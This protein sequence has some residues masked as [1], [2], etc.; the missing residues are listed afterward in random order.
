[1]IENLGKIIS[2]KE[3]VRITPRVLPTVDVNYATSIYSGYEIITNLHSY[4]IL[5]DDQCRCCE[6]WGYFSSNDDLEDFIGGDLTEVYLTDIN[7]NTKALPCEEVEDN[8]RST[9]TQF[10]NFRLSNGR[11][12]QFTVYNNHN[13]YYGHAIMVIVDSKIV[14]QGVL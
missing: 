3:C 9:N 2:I 1:M 14:H 7:L 13:G 11:V 6:W 4:Y 5:I 8:W 10:V 12:L